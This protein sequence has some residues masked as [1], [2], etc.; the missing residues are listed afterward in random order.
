MYEGRHN[1]VLRLADGATFEG[2]KGTL[3]FRVTEQGKD[4]RIV[5]LR[6]GTEVI[7]TEAARRERR[8]QEGEKAVR[9]AKMRE[10]AVDFLNRYGIELDSSDDR[11]PFKPSYRRIG[12]DFTDADTADDVLVRGLTLGH[13]RRIAAGNVPSD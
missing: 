2:G 13:L 9:R 11:G 6:D 5:F 8:Q 1:G 12:L 3:R 10:Q 4:P 7:E